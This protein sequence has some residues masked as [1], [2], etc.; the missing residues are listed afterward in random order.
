MN[1]DMK[2]LAVY[3]RAG[4]GVSVIYERVIKNLAQRAEVDILTDQ[5]PILDMSGVRKIYTHPFSKSRSKWYRKFVRWF[6]ATPFSAAWS[7][8][9]MRCVAD[10]Y[11]MVIAFVTSAQ[12]TPVIFGRHMTQRRGIKFAIY[13]VDAIP[14]P[15][16]WTKPR[17]YRG[18]MRV[19]ARNFAVADYVASSNSHMLEFQL[20][21]F[22]H[23]EGLHSNVLLTPS[24]A[25]QYNLP[26]GD[27]ATILYTGSLYGLRNPDHFFRA[28]KRLLKEYPEAEAIFVGMGMKFRGMLSILSREE[29]KHITVLRHTDNLE[30]LF[31]RATV[32]LDINADRESDPFLSSKIVTY[33]KTNRMI[34]SECGANTPTRDLFSGLDTIILAEHSA[35][36]LY[37]S[38]KLALERAHSNPDYSER[39]DVV[40][41]FSIE[42]V[43]TTLYNDLVELCGEKCK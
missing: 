1:D 34:V 38:L 31:R 13:S 20:T 35:D 26:M 11:D 18:K 28:F 37:N 6:G 32:L 36:S 27:R 29:L 23:K 33:L 17:E 21:T 25:E 15:G 7:R 22:K 9:A 40:K 5:S 14:A 24:P 41:R 10:D 19:V 3:F 43:S 30:P 42:E 8:E 2:I 12:L 39:E 16:G 4:S